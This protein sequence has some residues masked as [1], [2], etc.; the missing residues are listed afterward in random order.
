MIHMQQSFDKKNLFVDKAVFI[1]GDVGSINKMTQIHADE[2]FSERR[3]LFLDCV[4][5]ALLHDKEARKYPDVITFA[6]WIRKAHMELERAKY[7]NFHRCE[8]IK[9]IGQGTVFHVAPSNVAVNFAYSFVVSFITGNNSIV[10]IPS[11]DFRQVDIICGAINTVK[12][13]FPDLKDTICLVRYERNEMINDF[14]SG[15]CDVRVIWGGDNTINDIRASKLP[16]RSY[17]ITF[18]DRYSLALIDSEY[19]LRLSARDRN[20]V[21]DIAQ[22]FY[23]DTYLTDQNACTS[24]RL[25]VWTGKDE[26]IRKASRVFWDALSHLVDE[27]YAFQEIQG[28]DKL[29][30]FLL[31]ACE[32][33]GIDINDN[34]NNLYRV[35]LSKL[36]PQIMEY[37][38]DSGFFYE[39][40]LTDPKELTEF[41]SR[42]VQTL[43]YIAEREVVERYTKDCVAVGLDRIVPVGQSMDFDF[44]WDGYNLIDRMTR[45]VSII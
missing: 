41:I 34:R 14:L 12:E 42:K 18:S 27:Q 17:D 24:P 9:V 13:S 26:K 2:P 45:N 37:R 22:K 38:G 3:I 31:A 30:N 7:C 40:S 4:S 10:R 19:Y 5:K 32:I 44:I 35:Q 43:T 6:F 28:I 23:N 39:Y 21:G 11:K 16:V 25:V 29:S 15:F 33:D 8:T 20:C 1:V 36:V